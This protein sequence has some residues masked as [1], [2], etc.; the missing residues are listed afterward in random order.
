MKRVFFLIGIALLALGFLSAAMELAARAIAGPSGEG[1]TTLM[2]LSDVLRIV[3][4]GGLLALHKL[5]IWSWLSP[6]FDLPGWVAFGVPGMATVIVFR[7]RSADAHDPE[8][9]DSLFLFDEL[10]DAARREKLGGPADDVSL[11]EHTDIVPADAQYAE[12]L[13]DDEMSVERDFLL[14]DDR[15]SS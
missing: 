11:V 6:L 2:A 12:D 7:D 3:S 14:P 8:L 13:T 1:V 15:R 9:E 4:P 10:A 5:S